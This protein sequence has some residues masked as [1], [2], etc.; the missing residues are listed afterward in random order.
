MTF[1]SS[2]LPY[3]LI[4]IFW[5]QIQILGSYSMIILRQLIPTLH[6]NRKKSMKWCFKFT[7][8]CLP[9]FVTFVGSNLLHSHDNILRSFFKFYAHNPSIF[10]I[11]NYITQKSMNRVSKLHYTLMAI[12]CENYSH[13]QIF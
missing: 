4:N 6:K 10:G 9:Y 1:A 13:G 12:F 2:N 8:R 7:V 3:T 5:V 11:I